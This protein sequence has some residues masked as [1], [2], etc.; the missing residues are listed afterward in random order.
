MSD[1]GFTKESF[2]FLAGLSDNNNKAWF[3]ENKPSFETRLKAPFERLLEALS[4]RLSDADI[5]MQGSKK[6]MFRMHRDIRFSKDKRPYK[7][8][9]GALMTPDGRKNEKAPILYLHMDAGG[10]FAAAGFYKFKASDLEPIRHRMLD[11]ADEFDAVLSSLDKAGL[12]LTRSDPLKS[13]PRGFKDAD[14]HRHADKLQLKSLIVEQDLPK[15]VWISDDVTDQVEAFARSAMPLL[16][17][18]QR[19]L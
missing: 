10:G 3:D 4:E 17:F 19:A 9:T 7:T 15:S 12:S 16:Q 11:K 2:D 5:P 13:M 6:T 1:L 18:G 8:N 14:G